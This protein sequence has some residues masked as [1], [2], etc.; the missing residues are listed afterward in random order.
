[1]SDKKVDEMI[2][3]LNKYKLEDYWIRI[4]ETPE[5]EV[6]NQ[7]QFLYE[8]VFVKEG[9]LHVENKNHQILNFFSG[10]DVINQQIFGVTA[11]KKLNFICDEKTSLVYINREYFLN[12]ATNN[13]AYMKWFLDATERNNKNLYNEII[14]YDYPTKERI[15]HALQY[16][17]NKLRMEKIEGF[18]RIPFYMD[19][20]KIA[21]YVG[22]S[23]KEFTKILPIL[24]SKQLLE[25]R[26]EGLYVKNVD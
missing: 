22:V 15:V 13:P 5:N 25:K 21:N 12:F 14:K 18:Q 16:L 24:I 3:D 19:N 17:C 8:F 11:S 7:Y 10:G 6:I 23:C 20:E 26:N 1:M 4:E 9:V 2:V